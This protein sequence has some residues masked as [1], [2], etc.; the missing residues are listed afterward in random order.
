[1]YVARSPGGRYGSLVLFPD[2]LETQEIVF[3]ADLEAFRFTVACNFRFYD[4]A[5]Y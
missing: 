4:T 2:E 1:M 5:S 3:E